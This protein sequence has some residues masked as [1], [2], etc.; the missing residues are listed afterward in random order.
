ML[1]KMRSVWWS[2][3]AMA[4]LG[5]AALKK[6]SKPRQIDKAKDKEDGA[7]SAGVLDSANK[8]QTVEGATTRNGNGTAADIPLVTTPISTDFP[9]DTTTEPLPINSALDF[10]NGL[11]QDISLPS[12][13][14]AHISPD[15]LNFDA[16]FEKFDTVLGGSGADQSMELLRAFNFED[17]GSFGFPG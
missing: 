8:I 10:S 12:D 17:F 5:N 15:W 6:A 9:L 4:D 7:T 1:Q 16:A 2:A 3:G 14:N 13:M 11:D